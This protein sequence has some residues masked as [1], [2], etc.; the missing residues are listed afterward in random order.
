[1]KSYSLVALMAFVLCVPRIQAME[2]NPIKPDN[3]TQ[4]GKDYMQR[5]VD[6]WVKTAQLIKIT[7]GLSGMFN[8]IQKIGIENLIQDPVELEKANKKLYEISNPSQNCSEFFGFF[9]SS[10]ATRVEVLINTAYLDSTND[11]VDL[12]SLLLV[13]GYLVK[14]KEQ[15]DQLIVRLNI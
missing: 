5:T 12:K 8:D 3:F 10:I 14:E 9:T 13:M 11:A 7:T 6:A 15:Y 2:E 4:Y 1:M